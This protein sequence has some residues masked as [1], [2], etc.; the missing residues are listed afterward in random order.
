MAVPFLDQIWGVLG[1]DAQ[2]TVMQGNQNLPSWFETSDLA[3]ATMAAAGGMAAQLLTQGQS[4]VTIDKRLAS[5][6]FDMTLRPDG[7]DIPSLWD[8]IAGDYQTAD[9]WIR[10]HTN[11]PHHKR[12]AL[13]VLGD[14]ADRSSLQSAVM[15]WEKDALEHA[16]VSAKGCV[17]AMRDMDAWSQH[18][19]G[20]AV[21]AEPL[22][23][24]IPRNT[25]KATP[26]SGS[27]KGLK[28][29]DLTRVL[30]GPIATRFLAG[31]GADVLRIDPPDWSEDGVVPEVTLGK[32][33]AGLDL[34]KADDRK[35]FDKLLKGAD[36]LV[37]GYRADAL[38]RLGYGADALRAHNPK[39][40]DVC[41][42]AYGWTG[43]WKNRRG[44]DSLVQM[45]SGI[46]SY[47]MTMSGN[48]K[49]MPLPVQALDHG[50]GYLIAA[51]VLKCLQERASTGTILSA[52]LSLARVAHML[53]AT[54]RG[55]L[56]D[57]MHPA[58]SDD[59]AVAPEQTVWGQGHRIR[60]PLQ[61]EGIPFAWA[62]PASPLR[63]SPAEWL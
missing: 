57:A 46:A 59:Y 17:A 31:L 3:A 15:R 62:H 56:H 19:Q 40:I 22:I 5:L 34:R 35:I 49:P 48:D 37:H 55:N 53:T 10:L 42:N 25:V 20:Q 47:G 33:C 61:I 26:I 36:V 2:I 18:P 50:T 27:L 14:H 60:F 41:L 30:A 45:S 6:W 1:N 63:S 7:W 38:E 21:A 12:A 52:R 43:P 51:A 29:L 44:F 54:K 28:I 24:F 4:K 23:D 11:A 16:I 39:L 8:A 9:G 58:S 32:R 13:S